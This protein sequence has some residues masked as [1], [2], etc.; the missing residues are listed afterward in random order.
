MTYNTFKFSFYDKSDT[1]N[2]VVIVSLLFLAA[3]IER[4]GT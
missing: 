2:I 1:V 3:E 4:E